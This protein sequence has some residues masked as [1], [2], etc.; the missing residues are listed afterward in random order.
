VVQ[1]RPRAPKQQR[2]TPLSDAYAAFVIARQA[3]NVTPATLTYY[4]A[5]LLPFVTWCT[6][7]NVHEVDQ[8]TAAHVRAYLVTMQERKLAAWSVHGAARAI[9]AF[10]RFC[11]ADELIATAPKFAMP[12]LPK[13]VLPAFAPADVARLLDA[14]D[15]PRDRV[16]VLFLLDTGLRAAELVA[17]NGADIDMNND[18]VHVHQGKGRKDRT[19]YLGAKT[20][21]ELHRYWR[22]E[23]KPGPMAP[24]WIGRTGTR[25]SDSGLRQ[26]L[27]RIGDRADV[28]HCHPHTFR[29]TF[30]L[31]SLRAGMDIYTLAALMGHADITVLRQYLALAEDDLQN[32]HTRHGAVDTMLKR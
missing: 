20:C 23:Y 2:P 3:Q 32:A 22:A 29:R 6:S 7:K 31:W 5:R 9:R 1:K 18:A 28:D 12:K 19:V 21:R 30:A 24:A 17:L 10:L 26:L 27:E 16:I 14:C 25:L 13:H 4:A 8:V 11:V 15:T